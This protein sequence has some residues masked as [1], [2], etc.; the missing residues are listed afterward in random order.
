MR[1]TASVRS[2]RTR[3]QT[4]AKRKDLQLFSAPLSGYTLVYLNQENPKRRI[5]PRARRA[6]G[7]AACARPSEAGRHT[8][9]RSGC[10]GA[11]ADSARHLGQRSYRQAD[12]TIPS[13]R[14]NSWMRPAGRIPT[15]TAC[16]TRM[17]SSSPLSSWATTDD[18]RQPAR[19]GPRSVSRS[20]RRPSPSQA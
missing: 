1:S 11:I 12:S 3:L 9:A 15:A 8:P 14:A 6:P 20:R 19:P 4:A 2:G 17:G 7:V 10:G 13:R 5:L 16:G 18:D